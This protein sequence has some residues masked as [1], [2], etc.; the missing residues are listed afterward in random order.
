MKHQATVTFDEI[1]LTHPSQAGG[2]DAESFA[3]QLARAY[4]EARGD[5]RP[6]AADVADAAGY[7]PES[8]SPLHKPGWFNRR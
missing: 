3:M 2:A 4:F 8:P 5:G 6:F 1:E 7:A